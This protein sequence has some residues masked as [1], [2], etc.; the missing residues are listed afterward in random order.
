MNE[1]A[2]ESL[3]D[4]HEKTNEIQSNNATLS[5]TLMFTFFKI[6]SISLSL[7]EIASQ[8]TLIFYRQYIELEKPV[9]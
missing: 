1:Y 4:Q 5:F 2:L 7:T 6:F 9:L 3:N 8:P